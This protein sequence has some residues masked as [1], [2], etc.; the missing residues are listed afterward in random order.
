MEQKTKKYYIETYGCQM[1]KYDSELVAGILNKQGFQ[2]ADSVN[3]SDLILV[4]TCSVRQHAENRVLGRLDAFQV[5]KQENPDLM[6]GVLGCMAIRLQDQ[7]LSQKS[8]VN[9]VL[10]PDNYRALPDVLAKLSNGERQNRF[11]LAEFDNHEIYSELYPNRTTGFSAWV[12]I[13]RGCNNFCSYCIVPYLRGRERSRPAKDIVAEIEKLVDEGF[14]EVTLLGQNVNSYQD[15]NHDFAD[16]ITMV[17]KLPGLERVRFATSHP[18]DLSRKL[19]D[20]MA[21]HPK[22]C[23]H[24]HLP[25][26]SGSDKILSLMNR[27]YTRSHYLQLIDAVRD[28]INNPGLYTDIIVGFPGETEQDFQ[29]TVDLVQRVAFDG[30]FVFKY[31]PRE[32]TAAYQYEESLSE[33]EKVARLQYLNQIQD[34]ITLRRNRELVGQAQTILVEGRSRKAKPNQYMGRTDSNKIVVFNSDKNY[35][36]LLLEATVIAA[37]GRT[38]FGEII[39]GVR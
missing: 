16:L 26:Q 39:Q 38:L 13:M 25:V 30:A 14:L 8:M 12:A 33:Q 9:F 17:A 18:K 3:D 37:E 2:Q 10:G 5:L 23:N 15:E 20:A 34:A 29:D 28:R 6:I 7:L 27:K 32:G 36:G 19:I 35:D 11:S 22:I 24:L 4:N 31:S 1:N 21:A